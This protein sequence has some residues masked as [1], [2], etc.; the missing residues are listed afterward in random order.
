MDI[1]ETY[2]RVFVEAGAL[3]RTIDFYRELLHGEVSLRFAY[4]ET[5]LELAAV[6]S[7]RLFVLIIAG[8]GGRQRPFEA[9]RL[10]VRV[11]DVEAAIALLVGAG[12]EL[13]EPIQRTP[14]GRKT[15]L[16]HPDG[17]IA[18]YVEAA[19]QDAGA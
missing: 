12:A 19:A 2:T 11:D 17:L 14:V 5:G 16:R 8:D 9:T 10:T 1:L 4:P 6:S 15:R 18:E 7:P 3:E 13:L